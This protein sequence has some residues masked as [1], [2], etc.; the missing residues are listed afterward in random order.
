MTNYYLYRLTFYFLA[1]FAGTLGGDFLP[2]QLIYG[3]KTDMCHPKYTFPDN[4]DITHSENHWANQD[5]MTRYIKNIIIPYVDKIKDELDLPLGKKALVI[6][7]CFRGQLSAEFLELLKSNRLVYVCVPP[8]C[9]DLL[10]PMDLSVN[11]PA[12]DFLKSKFQQFYA[13]EVS[14]QFDTNTENI[15]EVTVDL[16]LTRLKPLGAMWLVQLYDY[17]KSNKQII[18]HGFDKAGIN[19]K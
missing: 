11:K 12:K 9:T 13:D 17:L 3:G 2:M 16:S 8:N 18:K 14:K 1:T 19:L 4:F 5:T 10:Q 7:D 6:F 15:K